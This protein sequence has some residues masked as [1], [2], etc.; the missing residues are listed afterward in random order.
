MARSLKTSPLWQLALIIVFYIISLI[1]FSL[2]YLIILRYYGLDTLKDANPAAPGVSIVWK[3]VTILDPVCSNLLPAFLFTWLISSRPIG[4][5]Q[6]DKSIP[7]K[8]ALFVTVIALLTFPLT[9]ILYDWNSTFGFA[10]SSLQEADE[11]T[12]IS[13]AVAEMPHA[14]YLLFNLVIMVLIPA[15][16]RECFFRGVLQQ[17]LIN[18]SPRAPWLAIGLTSVL[19]GL[20]FFQWQYIFSVTLWGLLLGTVYYLTENLWLAILGHFIYRSAFIIQYYFYQRQWTDE[21]PYHPAETPWYMG[22]ICLVG[23]AAVTWYCRKSIPR[24]VVKVAYQDDI[25]S[26]GRS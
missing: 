25:D 17:V 7:W 20:S 23:I 16:A 6:L 26:I 3:M 24:P 5:L 9:G 13:N 22:V 8:P 12:D 11:L 4:W 19:F 14:G 2:L 21:D 15:I 10:R 1:V 18:L